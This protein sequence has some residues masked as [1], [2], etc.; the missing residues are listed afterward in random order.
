M[1]NRVLLGM[2]GGVDSSVAAYLLKQKGY[3]VIGAI[4]KLKNYTTFAAADDAKR[5]CYKLGIPLLV[6]DFTA[7]FEEKVINYFVN[8]Y[9]EGRTP[10]PC[11]EC[12]KHLKF[13][14]FFKKAKELDAYYISTGHYARIEHDFDNNRYLVKKSVSEDKDQTYVLYNL[15]QDLLKHVL[16]PLGEYSKTE[17]RKIA[18]K[19]DLEVANKPDS[20]EICFIEDNNYINFIHNRKQNAFKPGNFVDSE[21]NVLGQHQGIGNYTIGQRKGLGIAVGKP[22]YV[23]DIIAD[24]NVIILGD[25][26]HVFKSELIAD[27]TNFIL[28]DTLYKPMKVKAKIRY[29]ANEAETTI[30]PLN[31]TRIKAI[32]DKPQRAI[33][34]G[35][36]IVFYQDEYLIGGGIIIST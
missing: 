25:E 17:I 32:F 23:V 33:T 36:S 22:L 35:Q 26:K 24:K 20:Q 14:A 8:E 12:N 15:T 10:N 3:E 5:I 6:L 7:I 1:N 4:M 27:N 21:G 16:L 28:F 18:K 19:I 31:K 13:D 11:I 29:T 30:I 34:K 9:F 2:S